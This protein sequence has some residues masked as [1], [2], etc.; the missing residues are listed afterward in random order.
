MVSSLIADFYNWSQKIWE[1]KYA[2]AEELQV[3]VQKI[4]AQKSEFKGS[5]QPGFETPIC[6]QPK[7]PLFQSGGQGAV[8]VFP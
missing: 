2:F 6:T 1:T 5:G 4:V 3:L 8:S 7:R